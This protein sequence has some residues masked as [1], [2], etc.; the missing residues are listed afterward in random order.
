MW[1]ILRKRLTRNRDVAAFTLAVLLTSGIMAGMFV[2]RLWRTLERAARLE[3]LEGVHR[4]CRDVEVFLAT[5]GMRGDPAVTDDDRKILAALDARLREEMA[6]AGEDAE[7]F[8]LIGR[9]RELLGDAAG[10]R[11][12]YRKGVGVGK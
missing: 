4:A 9:I 11:E 2:P 6:R 3:Q 10:A 12:A 8:I 7:G 1:Y 5:R